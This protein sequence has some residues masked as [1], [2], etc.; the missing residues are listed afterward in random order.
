METNNYINDNN[1]IKDWIDKYVIRTDN[2]K[3]RKKTTEIMNLY[4]EDKNT[5][6]Q[7]NSKEMMEF[8]TYNEFKNI[9]SKGVKYYTN[10]K[11]RE[12]EDDTDTEE[13]NI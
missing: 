1:P 13:N 10:I 8:M 7:L 6:R 4:N 2:I 3:D 11:I 12:I 9:K 5:E